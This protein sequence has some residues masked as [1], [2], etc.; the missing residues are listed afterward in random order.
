M[1][2]RY[3]YDAEYNG[4]DDYARFHGKTVVVKGWAEGYG[5]GNGLMFTV[6]VVDTG[7]EIDVYPGELRP[8]GE[9]K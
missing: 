3:T 1:G 9:T 6:T 8:E 4:F 5:P 7:D 2:Y